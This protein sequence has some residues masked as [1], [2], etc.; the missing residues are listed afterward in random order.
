MQKVTLL[1]D[2]VPKYGEILLGVGSMLLELREDIFENEEACQE[3]K[4]Y[5]INEAPKRKN[6]KGLSKSIEFQAIL[7]KHIDR[8]VNFKVINENSSVN[9]DVNVLLIAIFL[10]L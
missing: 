8:Y 2:F 10:K 5:I 4:E 1:L 6:L 7:F 3:L 9:K